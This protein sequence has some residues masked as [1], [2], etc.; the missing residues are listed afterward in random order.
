M[1]RLGCVLIAFILA[2][3]CFAMFGCNKKNPSGNDVSVK[4]NFL[5]LGDSIAEGILGASPLSEKNDYT[6]S[7]ILGKIN[8]FNYNNRGI[9]GYQTGQMLRYISKDGD[10]S[11]YTP[12]TLIK[13]A[14]IIS[15]S[16]SGNDYIFSDLNA[17]LFEAIEGGST[18]REKVLTRVRTNVPLIIARLKELNPDAT[19]MWQTLYNPIFWDSPLLMDTTYE[20]LKDVYDIDEDALHEWGDFLLDELNKVLFDYLEENPDSIVIPDV[21]AKFKAIYELDHAN[22]R[23]LIYKDGIHPSNYGHSVIASAIQEKIEECGFHGKNTLASYKK[24]SSERLERLYSNTSVNLSEVKGVINGAK[25]M[26]E[27]NEAY[28]RPTFGVIPDYNHQQNTL[29]STEGLNFMSA[30]TVFSLL[31]AKM[32]GGLVGDIPL[33]GIIDSERTTL[34]LRADGMLT[35]DVFINPLV[36]EL[37]KSAL[38]GIDLSTVPV[39]MLDIYIPELFPG[40]SIMG[41][42]SLLKTIEMTLG[43][44]VNGFDFEAENVKEIADA[45]ATT[46]KLPSSVTLPDEISFT[47]TQPYNL[48]HVDSDTEEGGYTAIYVGNYRGS[49]P[50]LILTLTEDV[51]GVQTIEVRSEFLSLKIEFVN[52]GDD[53]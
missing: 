34:T 36:Y 11:A 24:L 6:Y 46:G 38:S 33:M 41:L 29:T 47:F 45:L 4:Y 42:E 35:L 21:N 1:K 14:G 25:S 22:I 5:V 44:K 17:L 37:A 52:Y 7:G 18:L 26:D 31:S 16:M 40:E 30:D 12:I 15:I 3:S 48:V 39:E 13:N 20:T 51:W 10:D 28:F 19:I 32:S 9:S 2:V 23:R 50:Y 49:E 43:A 27:V 8:N 53:E